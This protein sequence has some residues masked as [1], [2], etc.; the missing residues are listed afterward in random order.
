MRLLLLWLKAS[1]AGVSARH[2]IKTGTANGQIGAKGPLITSWCNFRLVYRRGKRVA[3]SMRVLIGL[4][5]WH[6]LLEVCLPGIIH[7]HLHS[8]PHCTSELGC[9]I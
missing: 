6:S 8:V 2:S 9:G 4:A 7:H 5:C 1:S 3:S